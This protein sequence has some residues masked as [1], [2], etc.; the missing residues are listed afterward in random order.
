MTETIEQAIRTASTKWQTA[1]N[2]GDGEACAAC[3]EEDALMV[4]KPFGSFRGRTEI[5]AFWKK[6]IADGF[7][8]VAYVDPAIE[9]VD[10]QSGLLSAGW[11][12][13]KAQGVITKELWVVQRNGDA[14]LR[15]DYF[16]AQG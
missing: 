13:N 6:I 4:A 1:F 14:L 12:M 7:A 16:E 9:V 3:Y 8:D 5:A 2:A 15:E 10:D 11:T